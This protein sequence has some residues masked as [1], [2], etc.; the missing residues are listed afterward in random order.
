MNVA[1][2][3]RAFDA[4]LDWADIVLAGGMLT[5][6]LDLFA[7]IGRCQLKPGSYYRRANFYLVSRFR[8]LRALC[9]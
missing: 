7:L 8:W 4:A 1:D 3:E 9:F 2:D 5:Q 6:Q